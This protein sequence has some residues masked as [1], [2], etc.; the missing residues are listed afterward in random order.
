MRSTAESWIEP[1]PMKK[2]LTPSLR[3]R[4][5]LRSAM[6]AS[7]DSSVAAVRLATTTER[8]LMSSDP[9]SVPPSR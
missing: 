3:P 4:R 1:A 5:V 6:V 8:P 9:A 7:D 2:S